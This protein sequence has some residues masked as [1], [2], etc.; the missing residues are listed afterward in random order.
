MSKAESPLKA[1]YAY[2]QKIK[3]DLLK[4]NRGKFALIKDGKLLGT[5]D[6]DSD[7]YKFGLSQLGNVPFLIVRIIENDERES[8][9]ILELGL[10][11]AHL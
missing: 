6:T 4:S 8:I 5:F 10:L 1:D 11:N 9:P 3:P 2:Y 7:A